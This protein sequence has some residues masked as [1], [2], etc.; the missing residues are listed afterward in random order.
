MTKKRTT[1]RV[2]KDVYQDIT[3]KMIA[4]L[5]SGTLPW[6]K[7]FSKGEQGGN[8]E[9]P[10]NAISSNNYQGINT[11]L[12]W[13]EQQDKGYQSNTW[14]TFKQAADLK[15]NVMK[16]Q[17]GC[18]VIYFQMLDKKDDDK[19]VIGKIPMIKSYTVF[20]IEQ[21]ENIESTKVKIPVKREITYT[22]AL[23]FAEL[24]EAEVRHSTEDKAF[25]TP[26]YDFI[27]MPYLD[28][29]TNTENYD[30]TLL[31]ELSHWTGS[32]KRLDR[33]M[34]GTFGSTEYAKE[35]L[36]AELSSAF[37]AA[38]LGL[39]HE[40]L[41]H[42]TAAYLQSWLKALKGDKKFI[43]QAASRAQKA[44]NYLLD[45]AEVNQK[46]LTACKAA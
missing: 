2:K 31:H 23:N 7:P 34:K 45:I 24:C 11:L 36:T 8:C 9:L 6:V 39:K 1:K 41:H 4:C 15:G 10:H 25:Y 20:N 33:G 18:P 21:C 3:D 16:G 46:E 44:N 40:E 37:L 13:G 43:F 30:S 12:L 29:F 22:T 35:E 19:K 17:K 32:K 14:L 28:Q 27:Q 26:T 5:E 42:N 38:N